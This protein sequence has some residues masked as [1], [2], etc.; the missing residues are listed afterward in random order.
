MFSAD[1]EQE[2]KANR[3]ISVNFRGP[4]FNINDGVDKKIRHIQRKSNK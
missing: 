2:E 3:C 4:L 1:F